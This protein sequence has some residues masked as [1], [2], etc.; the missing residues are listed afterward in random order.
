MERKVQPITFAQED[1]T[2]LHYLY[3]DTLTIRAVVAQNGLKRMLVGNGSLVNIL[4]DST[5][6]K[7]Q[8]D[9]ELTLM[10]HELTLMTS[11]LYGF[12]GDS[13]ITRKNHPC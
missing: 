4:F 2:S 3:C 10:D 11:P 8:V 6:D 13:I 12:M 9:H 1:T 7:M 5:Y